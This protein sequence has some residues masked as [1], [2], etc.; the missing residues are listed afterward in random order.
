MP[1]LAKCPS[2]LTL[3]L[4]L[5][6]LR[7]WNGFPEPPFIPTTPVLLECNYFTLEHK[8]L[9]TMATGQIQ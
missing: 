2:E 7:G 1:T 5:G 9:Q 4:N 3:R 6:I 8:G